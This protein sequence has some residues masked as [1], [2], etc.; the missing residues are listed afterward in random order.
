ME[1]ELSQVGVYPSW[2]WQ[3]RREIND[4]VHKSERGGLPCLSPLP[5]RDA[6]IRSARKGNDLERSI[7]VQVRECDAVD[8]G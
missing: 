8:E 3:K 2:L 4:D 5:D 1:N 6:P 7:A